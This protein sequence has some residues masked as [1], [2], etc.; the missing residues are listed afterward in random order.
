[1]ATPSAVS[2]KAFLRDSEI[3]REKRFQGQGRSRPVA[4]LEVAIRV[5]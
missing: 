4:N 2:T 1:M 3:E 5:Y